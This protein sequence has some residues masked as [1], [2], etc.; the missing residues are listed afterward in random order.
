MST[1]SVFSA[2]I[3]FCS[4]SFSRACCSVLLA[5]TFS[6]SVWI[7]ALLLVANVSILQSG[8]ASVGIQVRL[9]VT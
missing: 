5:L 4:S 2:S 9:P 6:I 3:F 7:F 8:Q 1:I